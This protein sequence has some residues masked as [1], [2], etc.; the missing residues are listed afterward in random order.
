MCD[1]FREFGG[2]RIEE[3]IIITKDGCFNMSGDLP[4]TVEQIEKCMKG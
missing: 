1:Q 4:R 3:D 2:V